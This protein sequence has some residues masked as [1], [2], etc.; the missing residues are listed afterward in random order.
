MEHHETVRNNS[1]SS[2]ASNKKPRATLFSLPP[3]LRDK[4]YDWVFDDDE[5]I[6]T[7]SFCTISYP[8]PCFM[9]RQFRNLFS[10]SHIYLFKFPF[11]AVVSFANSS[12]STSHH[13]YHFVNGS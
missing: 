7:Q 9:V 13:P 10:S 6:G 2:S 3:E 12:T 11:P 4:I 5:T 1:I 8:L